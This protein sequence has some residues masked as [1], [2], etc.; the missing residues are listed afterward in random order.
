VTH[1]EVREISPI[2]MIL[3]ALCKPALHKER[4]H[5]SDRDF[6]RGQLEN[7]E[8]WTKEYAGSRQPTRAEQGRENDLR[9]RFVPVESV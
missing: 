5:M 3:R 9:I 8:I 4:N 2:D 6:D 7:C 1:I